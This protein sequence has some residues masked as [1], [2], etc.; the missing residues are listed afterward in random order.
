MV[1]RRHPHDAAGETVGASLPETQEKSMGYD[2]NL[3]WKVNVV[4]HRRHPRDAAG[5]AA[6]ASLSEIQREV[7]VA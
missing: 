4:R 7:G 5:E 2:D 1:R 3:D 6:G